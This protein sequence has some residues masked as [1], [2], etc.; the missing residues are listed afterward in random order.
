MSRQIAVLGAGLMGVATSIFLARGGAKVTLFEK[1]KAALGGASRWNEGKLHLGYLYA[2]DRSGKSIEAMQEAGLLFAP[3]VEELSGVALQDHVSRQSDAYLVHRDSALPVGIVAAHMAKVDTLLQTREALSTYPGPIHPARAMDADRIDRLSGGHAVAGFEIA[4]Y[5]VDTNWLAD[6]LL[7]AVANTANLSVKL[8]RSVRRVSDLSGLMKGPWQ[9]EIEGDKPRGRFDAVVNA[10]WEGRLAI[11][12]TLGL[13][14]ER[15]WSYRYRK[16]I[17]VQ[18]GAPIDV[19]G[20]TFITGPFGDIKNYD[21]RNFYVSWYPAG[22][23]AEGND[24]LPP[25]LPK[26]SDRRV[27]RDTLAG[28]SD[29]APDVATLFST[30]KEIKVEG[31]WIFAQGSGRL[32]DP[33]AS[34]HRRDRYGTVRTGSYFSV[35]TGKYST[36]PFL[37]R[38]LATRITG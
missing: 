27:L 2:A 31:G 9:I 32:D 15:D 13:T 33:A 8:G 22:L 37:A 26:V 16:S 25:S 30:A 12:Q 18:T 38:K 24:I 23:I 19:P 1:S 4:E 36:A 6:R 20:R 34:I 21:D 14:P 10:T 17:F 35:D 3:L 29:I 11:D 28:I 7:E 5:S